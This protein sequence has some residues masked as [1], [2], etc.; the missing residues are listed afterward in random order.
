[1]SSGNAMSM[2]KKLAVKPLGSTEFQLHKSQLTLPQGFPKSK[3]LDFTEY[4][5]LRL[6]RQARDQ[7]RK[8]ALLDLLAKYRKG[9]VAIG[10]ESGSKPVYTSVTRDTII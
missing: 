1:M 9:D 4:K 7:D 3:I 2:V 10:W 8:L 6:V 5:L